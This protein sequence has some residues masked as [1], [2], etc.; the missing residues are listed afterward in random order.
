MNNLRGILI[1]FLFL[2]GAY[3]YTFPSA[4]VA[5]GAIVLLHLAAG[6]LLVWKLL[7]LLLRIFPGDSP[8]ARLGWILL[9]TG[10]VVGLALIFTGTPRPLRP[11]LYAHIGLSL[12]G[13]VLLV[14][15]WAGVRGW[16]GSS[17]G[18]GVLRYAT[19]L[20]AFAVMAGSGSGPRRVGLPPACRLSN[21]N[22]RPPPLGGE[23]WWP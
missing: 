19:L 6:V 21:P 3:V 11:W 8:A 16:L 1:M 4:T 20:A 10:A 13:V 15:E 7:P 9:T 5:Y 12:A 23:G 2:S 17:S 18:A 22:G 14:G